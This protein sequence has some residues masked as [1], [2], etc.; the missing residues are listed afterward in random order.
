MILSQCIGQ[1][2][3]EFFEFNGEDFSDVHPIR[4][5]IIVEEIFRNDRKGYGRLVWNC[6]SI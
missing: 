6:S 2:K 4:T 5:H 3:G 1:M